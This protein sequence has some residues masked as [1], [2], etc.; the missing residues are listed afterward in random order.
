MFEDAA[1][2]ELLITTSDLSVL[3]LSSI[4][5][6]AHLSEEV[7]GKLVRRELGRR[8][9][10]AVGFCAGCALIFWLGMVAVGAMVRSIVANVPAEIEKQHGELAI[11]ELGVDL[12]VFTNEAAQLAAIAQP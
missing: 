1:Q 8:I 11:K 3:D 6:L 12:A 7:T 5:Q 4:P 9:K 10:I 2:P